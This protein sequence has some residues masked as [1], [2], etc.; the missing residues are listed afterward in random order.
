MD[1]EALRLELEDAGTFPD[2]LLDAACGSTTDSL[3]VVV[4]GFVPGTPAIPLVRV[5][6]VL[7]DDE[8]DSLLAK[9]EDD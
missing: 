3:V 9:D 6:F 4:V 2:E 8:E 7:V 1:A 5:T